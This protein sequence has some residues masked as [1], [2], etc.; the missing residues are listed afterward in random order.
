MWFRNLRRDGGGGRLAL[1]AAAPVVLALAMAGCS[2]DYA[3]QSQ[4]TVLFLVRSINSGAALHSS[5]SGPPYLSC[6]TTAV[7]EVRPKNVNLGP[8]SVE[9][10][11]VMQY[12]VSYRRSDGRGVEGVDV[13]YRISGPMSATVPSGEGISVVFEIVRHAAKAEPPLIKITDMNIATM[14]AD[15]TFY[16]ETISGQGVEA[17]GTAQITFAD[18]GTSSTTCESAS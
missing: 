17:S 11:R 4:A 10:V 18:F 1:G 16:G 3:E 2:A 14:F 5:T 7:L 15:V 13:P 9:D 8:T 12:Q 6:L